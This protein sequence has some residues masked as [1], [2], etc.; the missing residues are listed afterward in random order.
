MKLTITYY[1]NKVRVVLL[2]FGTKDNLS[3]LK[4]RGVVSRA[5]ILR[6][7][8]FIIFTSLV[9][10]LHLLNINSTLSTLF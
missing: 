1:K 4:G 9:Q 8:P 7:F 6:S 2:I 3:H 5:D 10:P